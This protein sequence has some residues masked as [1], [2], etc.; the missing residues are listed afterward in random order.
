MSPYFVLAGSDAAPALDG[1]PGR[2]VNPAHRLSEAKLY[3]VMAP[4]RGPIGAGWPKPDDPP[5]GGRGDSPS[6]ETWLSAQGIGH[7]FDPGSSPPNPVQ[8]AG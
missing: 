4:G 3:S 6:V 1:Q 5:R 8:R 2:A 7:G